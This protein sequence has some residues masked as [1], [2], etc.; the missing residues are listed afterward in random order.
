V[1]AEIVLKKVGN[2]VVPGDN[3][4]EILQSFNTI[5]M[6]FARELYREKQLKFT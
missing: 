5:N 4:A 2:F 1:F 6:G 3:Q